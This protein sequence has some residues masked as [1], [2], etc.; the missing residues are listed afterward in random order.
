MSARL[1][2]EGHRKCC[3]GDPDE[4][5]ED[6]FVEGE[7]DGRGGGG[8]EKV[9]EV[10]EGGGGV[11]DRVEESVMG[12]GGGRGG[13]EELVVGEVE[14]DVSGLDGESGGEEEEGSDFGVVGK[15]EDASEKRDLLLLQDLPIL[16]P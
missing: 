6:G 4:R 15:M 2:L 16:L 5:G 10:M 1:R 13:G 8:G 11:R 14:E 7:I 9:F 3:C 12:E